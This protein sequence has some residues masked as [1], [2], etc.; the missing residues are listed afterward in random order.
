MRMLAEMIFT[1]FATEH[2]N[3]QG[4]QPLSMDFALLF[5]DDAEQYLKGGTSHELGAGAF[6]CGQ[7][8]GYL[9]RGSERFEQMRDR[10]R[11]VVGSKLDVLAHAFDEGVIN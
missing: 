5:A 3:A 10:F 4:A 9:E 8:T 2:V 7:V 6:F 11:D 1:Y